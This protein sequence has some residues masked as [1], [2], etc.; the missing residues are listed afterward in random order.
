M[1]RRFFLIAVLW[2]LLILAACSLPGRD[3]PQ[4]DMVS[5]D[6]A[7]HFIMFASFGGLW[8][9]AFPGRTVWVLAA[10]LAF[11]L[12][13]EIYQGFLPFERTPDPYDA[14]FNALGLCA[15]VVIYRLR[16]PR[17]ASSHAPP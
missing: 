3:L 13:T 6:K 16:H 9:R 15:A 12:F 14:L 17:P 10:G 11:A 8:M 4:V 7:V 2:T 5:F 1:H